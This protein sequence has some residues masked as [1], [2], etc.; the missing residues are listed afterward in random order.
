MKTLLSVL[1]ATLV[2]S[3]AVNAV[4][5]N[6]TGSQ[7]IP[8]GNITGIESTIN[9]SGLGANEHT[10]ESF[11]LSL[12]I[13]GGRNGDLFA[14]LTHDGV[15]AVL[16]NRVGRGNVAG[17]YSDAG[18]AVTFSDVGN[19][20]HSY[21][22]GTFFLDE[23]GRLMGTWGADGRDA[24]PLSATATDP[25]VSNPFSVFTGKSSGGDWTLFL[26]DVNGNAAQGTLESW[27]L[28]ITAV[29]EPTNVALG[30]FGGLFVVVQGVRFWKKKQA[31]T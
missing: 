26:A 2:G 1:A 17:G 16:L 21:Q 12:T 13:T 8:D 28:D 27:S 7:L 15:T 6:S 20:I 9:V 14:Y 18:F 30:V 31:T 29:P 22:S 24:S 5:F 4:V 3:T 10:V 11:T 19:D 23:S 25:R